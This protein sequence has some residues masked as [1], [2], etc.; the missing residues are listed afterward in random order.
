MLSGTI[1]LP[2]A[3]PAVDHR[4]G[5][6][7]G[8]TDS[9]VVIGTGNGSP[10][11]HVRG[12]VPRVSLRLSLTADAADPPVAA[13]GNGAPAVPVSARAPL[14]TL[15]VHIAANAARPLVPG[16]I[17]RIRPLANRSRIR[18]RMTLRD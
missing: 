2:T 11:V 8:R 13:A 12:R 6:T 3:S 5:L 18:P 15:R 1:P 14:V 4:I 16:P 17:C 9:G 10:T 7:A